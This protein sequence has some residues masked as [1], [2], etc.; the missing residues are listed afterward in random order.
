MMPG[1]GAQGGEDTRIDKQPGWPLPKNIWQTVKKE[2]SRLGRRSRV[3][4]R[5]G[6]RVKFMAE[7]MERQ[8]LHTAGLLQ[9]DLNFI[10]RD[11]TVFL[12]RKKDFVKACPEYSQKTDTLTN[13]LICLQAES[14]LWLDFLGTMD[15]PSPSGKPPE[16]TAPLN[17]A[18]IQFPGGLGSSRPP[19]KTRTAGEW[20]F[21][22][23]YTYTISG[24]K[25]KISLPKVKKNSPPL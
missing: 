15:C 22:R 21:C 6:S 12:C 9:D 18:L 23:I 1:S 14:A 5:R 2:D 20:D 3:R 13:V 4:E 24:F 7:K 17:T 11:F 16:S 10:R 19:K 8:L 25:T